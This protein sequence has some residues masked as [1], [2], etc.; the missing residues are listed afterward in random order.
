MNKWIS[1]ILTKRYEALSEE[2]KSKE[3]LISLVE[4]ANNYEKLLIGEL[5]DDGVKVL[6]T[7]I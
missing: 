4:Q 3:E 1:E 6:N 7:P 5:S 2:S